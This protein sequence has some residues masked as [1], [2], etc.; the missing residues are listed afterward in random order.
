MNYHF[1]TD[2]RDNIIGLDV[3]VHSDGFSDSCGSDNSRE[4]EIKIRSNTI[5]GGYTFALDEQPKDDSGY[6]NE[7]QTLTIHSFGDLERTDLIKAFKWILEMLEK[8]K[9]DTDEIESKKTSI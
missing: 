4:T 5:C 1:N 6:C 8:V 9:K 7:P 3:E 2:S